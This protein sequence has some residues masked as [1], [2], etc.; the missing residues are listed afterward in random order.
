MTLFQGRPRAPGARGRA[1]GPP[2]A[3]REAVPGVRFG[4]IAKPPAKSRPVTTAGLRPPSS[5]RRGDRNVPPGVPSVTNGLPPEDPVARAMPGRRN[6][7]AA[8]MDR[9]PRP[10]ARPP[11]SRP[12]SRAR[13]RR[14]C[15]SCSQRTGCRSLSETSGSEETGPGPGGTSSRAVVHSSVPPV[16]HT[17]LPIVGATRRQVHAIAECDHW[18]R[19]VARNESRPDVLVRDRAPVRARPETAPR[20][21]ATVTAVTI[22]IPAPPVPSSRPV[23]PAKHACN[24]GPEPV[25]ETLHPGAGVRDASSSTS[26]P[27]F[28]PRAGPSRP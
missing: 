22:R 11:A 6:G 9:A 15:C 19:P 13:D 16:L 8:A 24:D 26:R 18:R 14:C 5:R 7:R 28:R 2:G 12:S 21:S 3:L 27:L 17:P 23:A 1:I 25:R 20:V 10:T 4:G